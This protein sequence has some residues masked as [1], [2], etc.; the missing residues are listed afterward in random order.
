MVR[1]GATLEILLKES[2]SLTIDLRLNLV[3]DLRSST[4]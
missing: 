4:I 2:P 1:L 3:S